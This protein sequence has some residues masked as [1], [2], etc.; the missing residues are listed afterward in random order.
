MPQALQLDQSSKLRPVRH[1][2]V[3]WQLPASP[4]I[5]DC[6]LSVSLCFDGQYERRCRAGAEWRRRAQAEPGT[7]R[8][9][10]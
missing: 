3:T 7:N 4:Q 1:A 6:G 5:L 9:Q 10:Q 8:V 2:M